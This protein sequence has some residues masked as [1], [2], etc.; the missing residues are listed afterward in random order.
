MGNRFLDA[1]DYGTDLAGPQY[2]KSYGGTLRGYGARENGAG[3]FATA[4]SSTWAQSLSAGDRT[5]IILIENGGVDLGI[6]ALVDKLL[7]S[8]PGAALLPASF[9]ESLVAKLGEKIRSFTDN[10]LESAELSLNR[11][12]AAKPSL[13][14]DVDTLRDG[15]SSFADLKS[16][17]LGLSK[18][19]K[20]IDLFILTHGSSDFISIP[21]GIN[22]KKIRDM[23]AENGKPL[24]IRSVYMMNCVGSS[25]NQA[26]L[27]A[28][29]KV[30]A[31]ALNNN[32]LPEP[33]MYF[34]WKNWQEGQT[35]ENA[36]TSAYRKTI[37][38]MNEAVRTIV[39][40]LPGGSLLANAID[41]ENLS[42]VKDS[43]PVI[44]G[45]RSVT[46][47]S[48]DLT[49]SQSMA[50]SLATTILPVKLLRSFGTSQSENGSAVATR[51][52][53]PQGM[54]FLKT[55]EDLRLTLSNDRLACMIGYGTRLHSGDCDGRP[56]EDRYNKGISKEDAS[57]CL[58]T[59]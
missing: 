46:I 12:N 30:S 23:K 19:G 16:K 33:T 10:L 43:A 24:T 18:A 49:F 6:P 31:G 40:Q 27:D 45:Q 21:G 9:R 3:R 48:D 55:L 44:Q 56:S 25:L 28:G 20:I 4:Q 34:F 2:F 41:F 17:L 1:D 14:G 8:I 7:A 22:G 26:W 37:N 13:F 50:S 59:R 11:Y 51:S 42:F 38:L 35:F 57:N 47:S 52:L 36:V 5:L 53:S 54:E 58:R 32:Y 29:A 15:T 39:S